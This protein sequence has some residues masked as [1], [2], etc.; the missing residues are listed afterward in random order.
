MAI[1]DTRKVLIEF[2]GESVECCRMILIPPAI[3]SKVYWRNSERIVSSQN[4]GI[5]LNDVG[6]TFAQQRVPEIQTGK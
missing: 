6:K 2:E 4:N 5:D 3:V 1:E